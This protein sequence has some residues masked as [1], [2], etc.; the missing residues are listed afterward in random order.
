MRKFLVLILFPT[1]LA[2]ALRA[3]DTPK[4]VVFGGYQFLQA[5]NVDGSNDGASTNGWNASGT[6]NFTKYLGVA[7][8]FGGSY[9]GAVAEPAI[10]NNFLPYF[11]AY[12]YTFGPVFSLN[13]G[14]KINPFA[15]ALFGGAHL[16]PTECVVFGAD[17]CGSNP[18]YSGL[19]MMLGGGLDAR[20]GKHAGYR[21]LQA[22]WVY[23]PVQG[24]GG[25]GGHA[26]NVRLST[27]FIFIF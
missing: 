18:S 23:L 13:S 8:D 3:Q 6:F 2:L 16:S 9:K 24:S 26:K 5:G 11:H 14:G 1:I 12:T 21:I 15:H 27:G 25:Q 19:A 7:A 17:Q 22:D 10:N 20:T 4:L